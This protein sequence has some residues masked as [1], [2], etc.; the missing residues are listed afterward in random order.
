MH[1]PNVSHSTGSPH[2]T[3]TGREV[4]RVNATPCPVR[5]DMNAS[6]P[7]PP[8]ADNVSDESLPDDFERVLVD[9]ANVCRR[10]LNETLRQ[11][12]GVEDVAVRIREARARL[13]YL[14]RQLSASQ[15]INQS[16]AGVNTLSGEGESSN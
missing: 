10:L 8:R 12:V 7:N 14:E 4:D 9:E 2:S 13:A 11:N 15:S 5:S 1:Q 16:A 6:E 3:L